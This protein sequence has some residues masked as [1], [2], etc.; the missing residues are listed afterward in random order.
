LS[1]ESSARDVVRGFP[2][3]GCDSSLTFLSNHGGFSGAR[4]WRVQTRDRRLCLRAW[5]P[6]PKLGEHLTFIHGL[7]NGARDRGL[8]FVPQVHQTAQGATFVPAAGRLWDLTGWMEGRADFWQ[9]PT[10]ARLAA[11]A[12]VLAQLHLAWAPSHV[13]SAPCPAI[14]RRIR[15]L[16]QWNGLL[17]AGWRPDFPPTELDPCVNPARRAWGLLA[18]W[19]PKLPALVAPWSERLLPLQPCLCDVWH[20][21]ILYEGDR[22]SGVIDY[23]SAKRDHVA[24]DLARLLGSMVGDDAASWSVALKAYRSVAHFTDEEEALARALD[25]TG[26]IVGLMNWMRWL[27]VE[28]REFSDREAAGRRLE[29]LVRRVEGW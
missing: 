16:Q 23:G 6:L 22:V 15:R 24:V 8:P 19:S 3:V 4:L 7:M 27:Y 9:S 29:A 17:A 13:R 18:L 20:D 1:L 26:T 11:A 10:P 2:V 28:G 21:H 14:H 12:T 25:R 5:P